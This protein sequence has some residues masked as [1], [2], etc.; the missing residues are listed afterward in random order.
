[1]RT[2]FIIA[3]L[4]N[5]AFAFGSVPWMPDSFDVAVFI[6]IAV[7]IVMI[8]LLAVSS[9]PFL[10]MPMTWW[11]TPNRNYWMSEEN[12]SKAIQ[13]SRFYIATIGIVGTLF[14]PLVQLAHFFQLDIPP[15]RHFIFSIF[16]AIITFILIRCYLSFYRLPKEQ[17]KG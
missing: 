14:I 5:I 1:M 8:T 7:C 10:S 2:F 15:H 9:K 12:F 16:I 3:C 13:K 17:E 11:G 6:G 4:A